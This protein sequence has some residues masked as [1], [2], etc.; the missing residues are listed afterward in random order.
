[1]WHIFSGKLLEKKRISPIWLGIYWVCRSFSSMIEAECS[2]CWSVLEHSTT[3]SLQLYWLRRSWP[4]FSLRGRKQPK[5]VI[6]SSDLWH[7]KQGNCWNSFTRGVYLMFSITVCFQLNY[8]NLLP[9]PKLLSYELLDLVSSHFNLKEKEFFGLAFFDDK[10][11]K[12]EV[13]LYIHPYVRVCACAQNT[14]FW[15]LSP[16]AFAVVN[17]SGY[18]WTAEFLTTTFPRSPGPLPSTSW[19]GNNSFSPSNHKLSSRECCFFVACSSL[20]SIL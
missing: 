17:V 4:N 9:Q 16:F 10:Y 5:K 18:R 7:I 8:N 19:S 1:M 6:S 3:S 12:C 11:V 2:S 20:Q 15:C 14:A 13:Y